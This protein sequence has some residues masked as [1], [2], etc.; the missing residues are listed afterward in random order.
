MNPQVTVVAV[1]G[2]NRNR[3]NKWSH[4]LFGCFDDCGECLLACC[5]PCI[6]FGMNARDS[7]C[8]CDG[9]CGAFCGCILFFCPGAFCAWWCCIRPNIRRKYR[10]PTNCC[11]D[12]CAI[13]C[14][15][16]CALI[17]ER[18]QCN[19]PLPSNTQ[20]V[21]VQNPVITA[22]PGSYSP[23]QQYTQPYPEQYPQGAPH[24]YH[25]HGQYP[26]GSQLYHYQQGPPPQY[27]TKPSQNP[28]QKE[29]ERDDPPPY[30][31]QPSAPPL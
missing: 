17:Q 2:V 8:C 24:Q 23:P 16:C 25:Q 31:L 11:A 30:T 15:A 10:I 19:Q 9:C 27:P 12:C 14:C 20:V 28:E 7:G 21:I 18:Q 1:Q 13:L 4:G 22:P 3:M 6:T 29:Q 26:Q 5:C